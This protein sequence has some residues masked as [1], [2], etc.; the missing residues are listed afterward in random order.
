M[1]HTFCGFAV[2]WSVSYLMLEK[3]AA[4]VLSWLVR[5]EFVSIRMRY[6]EVIVSGIIVATSYF[7]IFD[8]LLQ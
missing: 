1:L 5:T 3:S 4:F 7:R 6:A 8:S 2:H